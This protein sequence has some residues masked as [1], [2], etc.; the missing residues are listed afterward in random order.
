M[1]QGLGT[2]DLGHVEQLLDGVHPDHAGLVE[3]SGDG[4]VR[5]GQRGRM[6]RG[7][8]APDGAPAA[9][10]GDD[11]FGAAE[12]AGQASEPRGL[13]NDSRYSRPTLVASSS[14]HHESRSLPL[15][16]ALLPIETKL[17]R[18]I[19]RLFAS[20]RMAIPSPPDCEAKPRVPVVGVS[21]AKVAFMETPGSVLRTPKRVRAHHP[22]PVG[23]GQTRHHALQG[24]A[25]GAVLGE[26]RRDDDQ[27]TDAFTATL[28]DDLG[29]RTG[30]YR[31]DG[32]V[33]GT[34][35]LLKAG[36]A[37]HAGDMRGRRVDRVNGALERRR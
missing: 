10:Y 26:V 3:Q 22:H 31:H 19:P 17:E 8:P 16:S 7:G 25:V 35:D 15:T 12:L 23:V 27:A 28:V 33:N 14:D 6:R 21:L 13:P 30:R 18:P 37:G 2:D 5:A 34:W 24:R 9:L 32:Q 11:G 29:H 1:S 20:A 36:E 4:I